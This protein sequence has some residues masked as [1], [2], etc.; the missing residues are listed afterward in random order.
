MPASRALAVVMYCMR[1]ARGVLRVADLERRF[2]YSARDLRHLLCETGFPGARDICRVAR[3]GTPTIAL[4]GLRFFDVPS[5]EVLEATID[6][7]LRVA[8]TSGGSGY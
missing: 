7:I 3:S 1:N 6:S 4:N 2:G 5:R 8:R